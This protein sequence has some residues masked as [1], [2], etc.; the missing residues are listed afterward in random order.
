MLLTG[1][2]FD[3][4]TLGALILGLGLLVDDAIISIEIMRPFAIVV[5]T[6]PDE[7]LFIG[8][9]GDPAFTIDSGPGKA[10]VSSKDEGRYE[11]GQ[12]IAGRRING[13]EMFESGLPKTKIGMLKVKLMRIH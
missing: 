10:F 3:R 8:A 11:N 4:I 2:V 6:A 5:N 7:F 9:N 12:W 1:R 13:D